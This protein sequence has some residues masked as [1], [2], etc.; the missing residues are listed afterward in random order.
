M[1]PYVTLAVIVKPVWE[2]VEMLNLIYTVGK[3]NW[4]FISVIPRDGIFVGLPVNAG[5]YVTDDVKDVSDADGIQ[6][7]WPKFMI[8]PTRSEISTALP[9]DRNRSAL[10]NST[11]PNNIGQK[12]DSEPCDLL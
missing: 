2:N 8:Y 3:V 7:N 11:Q 9:S 10:R 4:W 6:T 12:S 1:D 5:E